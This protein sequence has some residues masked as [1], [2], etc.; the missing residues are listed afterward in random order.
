MGSLLQEKNENNNNNDVNG[1]AN[2]N[3]LNN[4]D[5]DDIQMPQYAKRMFENFMLAYQQ[6]AHSQSIM[7]EELTAVQALLN[8][9]TNGDNNGDGGNKIGEV[10]AVEREKN[11]LCERLNEFCPRYFKPSNN[12]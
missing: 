1:N 11:T 10:S 9:Q 2:D 8:R 5:H 7:Q 3:Q 6:Y 12:P 4:E